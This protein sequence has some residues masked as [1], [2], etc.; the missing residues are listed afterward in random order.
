MREYCSLGHRLELPILKS[1]ISV[2][3]EESDFLPGLEIKGAYTAGLAAKK[4]KVYAKDSIDF[5][6]TTKDNITGDAIK[7]WGFEAKGRVTAQSAAEEERNLHYLN[8][9]HLRIADNEVHYE[10]ANEGER[11]QVLQHA[12][13]YDFD[14]VVLAISDNQSTLIRSTV[15]DFTADLKSP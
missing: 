10:V 4:N 14:T 11:F 1:W 15:I 3:Q 8:S 6:L 13:V 7:T 2:V 5:V 12:Y 9:P